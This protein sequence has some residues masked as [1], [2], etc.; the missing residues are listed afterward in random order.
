[1][2]IEDPKQESSNRWQIV[3]DHKKVICIVACSALLVTIIVAVVATQSSQPTDIFINGKVV[4]F[5][6][7]KVDEEDAYKFIPYWIRTELSESIITFSA[8]LQNIGSNDDFLEDFI[9]ALKNG[10]DFD[11]YNFEC[12]PTNRKTYRDDAYPFEFILMKSKGH[13]SDGVPTKPAECKNT[14][15]VLKE[16]IQ[17]QEKNSTLVLP[18]PKTTSASSAKF[19]HLSAF[20][21]GDQKEAMEVFKKTTEELYENID[22]QDRGDTAKWYLSSR[23]ISSNKI[24][25]WVH[26]RIDPSPKYYQYN[27]YKTM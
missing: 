7:T 22:D 14:I 12:P 19:A 27:P 21:Q 2:D 5:K 26:L 13:K 11:E 9:G 10:T 4:K 3:K 18:C 20:V 1:M 16:R 23:S 6:R 15:E 24:T 25:N 8:F 17:G